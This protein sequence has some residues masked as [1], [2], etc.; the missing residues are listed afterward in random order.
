MA[1]SCEIWQKTGKFCKATILQLKKKK[2]KEETRIVIQRNVLVLVEE[3]REIWSIKETQ[4]TVTCLED[5]GAEPWAEEYWW[6]LK[7]GNDSHSL[8]GNKD[9]IPTVALNW[10]LQTT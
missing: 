3:A 5:G 8:H 9:F 1:E 6:H 7:L 2:A 4:P 10:I